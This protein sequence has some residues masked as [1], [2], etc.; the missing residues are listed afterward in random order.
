M[1]SYVPGNAPVSIF[2][3][4]F[5]RIRPLQLNIYQNTFS[6]NETHTS[7]MLSSVF[8][9]AWARVEFATI[10]FIQILYWGYLHTLESLK[11]SDRV[12]C[13]YRIQLQTKCFYFMSSQ[14]CALVARL[15][16]IFPVLFV[17]LFLFN[18]PFALNMCTLQRCLIA[19]CFYTYR[20]NVVLK[21]VVVTLE[22][23][24]LIRHSSK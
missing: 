14:I 18:A 9:H 15:C 5:A 21:L 6:M 7:R 19:V 10:S 16:W 1:R 2:I 20:I 22:L 4:K 8:S 13:A 3:F 11:H 12:Q 23:I 24:G 17:V